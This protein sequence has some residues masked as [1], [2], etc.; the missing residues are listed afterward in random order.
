MFA[1]VP[2]MQAGRPPARAPRPPRVAA[3]ARA[4]RRAR[5]HFVQA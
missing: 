5:A 3:R 2:R 1:R 4:S